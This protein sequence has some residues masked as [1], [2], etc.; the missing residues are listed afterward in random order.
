MATILYV[1][2]HGT[3]NPNK[4]TFPFFLARGAVEAGHQ[5]AIMLMMEGVLAMKDAMVQSIHGV[6]LPPLKE[7]MDYAIQH[8]IPIT[9]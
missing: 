4:A 6:G 9:V 3:D 2:T 7:V 8:R 1:G 5:P